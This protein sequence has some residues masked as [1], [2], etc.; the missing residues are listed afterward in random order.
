M[1]MSTANPAIPPTT[2]PTIA[3]TLTELLVAATAVLLAD[4]VTTTIEVDLTIVTE[5]FGMVD[6]EENVDTL[7]L[8]VGV[9]VG[10]GVEEGV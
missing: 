5:P 6:N 8:G 3:P 2:P 10:V 9:G 4:G 7:E 1:K